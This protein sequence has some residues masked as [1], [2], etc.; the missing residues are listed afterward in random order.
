MFRN[1]AIALFT[2]SAGVQALKSDQQEKKYQVEEVKPEKIGESYEI[3]EFGKK[4][5]SVFKSQQEQ[6]GNEKVSES[7]QEQEAK[8]QMVAMIKQFLPFIKQLLPVMREDVSKSMKDDEKKEFNDFFDKVEAFMEDPQNADKKTDLM[9]AMR[10]Q[11]KQMEKL[12]QKQMEKLFQ[13]KMKPMMPMMGMLL[14][15]IEQMNNQR[16]MT[17]E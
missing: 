8:E 15:N 5:E 14:K 17:L 9:N 12:F 16:I 13:K 10:A 4:V 7:Q 1:T 11:M 6:E 3:D 2:A